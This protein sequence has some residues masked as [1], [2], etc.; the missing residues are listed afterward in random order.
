MNPTA[1]IDLIEMLFNALSQLGEHLKTSGVL[2]AGH[3]VHAQLD[4]IAD[5]VLAVKTAAA[6]K[7]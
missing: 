4:A 2:P 1:I 6:A 7:P 5:K 3:P